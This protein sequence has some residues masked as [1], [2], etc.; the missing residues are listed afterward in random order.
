MKMNTV[1]VL[2]SAAL[3]AASA[4]AAAGQEKGSPKKSE[5][6]KQEAQKQEK[7]EKKSEPQK[8]APSKS[9][10]TS[11]ENN[12][13]SSRS[14]FRVPRTPEEA[15]ELVRK[16][17]SMA[18]QVAKA[19]KA[20]EKT[21]SK[22]QRDDHHRDDYS[23]DNSYR[24]PVEIY[25]PSGGR[26]RR[27]TSTTGASSSG[28]N[29]TTGTY[30]NP[31]LRDVA[32]PFVLK[33][34]GEYYLYRTAV[35]GG[36]DVFTSCDLVNWTP[37][38]IVWTPDRPDVMN[39]DLIWAP[40]IVYDNGTF[41]LYFSTDTPPS[42]TNPGHRIWVA[43]ADSPL[44]PFK[45][46]P[47]PALTEAWR[48]DPTIFTDTDGSRYIYTCMAP[49]GGGAFVQGRK[50]EGW[51]KPLGA[52]N[53]T[54]I[55][56]ATQDW[57]GGW[58]EGPTVI[59]DPDSATPRY[60]MLYS[61]GGAMLPRYA[62][63]VSVA[64]SPLGPW[65][66]KGLFLSQKPGVPGPG[67]QGVTLAPDNL[68][69]EILYHKK[70]TTEEGWGRDLCVD[71][72]SI[73]PSGLV[74]NAP[75]LLPQPLPPQ[76]DFREDFDNDKLAGWSGTAHE[77]GGIG[78]RV[79]NGELQI[80]GSLDK[81]VLVSQVYQTPFDTQNGLMVEVNM[82]RVAGVGSVGF[83]LSGDSATKPITV[84]LGEGEL[85]GEGLSN[86][87]PVTVL[88]AQSYTPQAYHQVLVR[89]QAAQQQWVVTADGKEVLRSKEAVAVHGKVSLRLFASDATGAFDGIAVTERDKGFTVLQEAAR[90]A[91][92]GWHKMKD[93]VIEQRELG[94]TDQVYPLSDRKV[95]AENGTFSVLVRGWALGRA[96][97]YPKYGTRV[98]L[99]KAGTSYVDAYIDPPTGVLATHAV[100]DG[101]EAFTWQNS[102]LPLGFNFTDDH[103]ITIAWD[104]AGQ[105]R[106][107]V[108][109]NATQTRTLPL[110][111]GA[112]L[113]P[114]LLTADCRAAY[115]DVKTQ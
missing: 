52:D 70:I 94:A 32:D 21:A 78:A 91:L 36:I 113:T 5:P 86:V 84:L 43:T 58:T 68:T 24:W 35:R 81:S 69:W 77:N 3:T 64:S 22:V 115:R 4:C 29:R 31:V 72:F 92:L 97:A 10:S 98:L 8:D 71:S 42:A 38:P 99:N 15:S 25:V 50:F 44:G 103:K 83:M 106:F 88:P 100:V 20:I 76:P 49:P 39:K 110:P 108:D 90:P 47:G 61:G 30:S 27:R 37:G 2:V 6:Q 87:A 56:P 101:K 48:I 19:S 59:R 26:R 23:Y 85:K 16:I 7:Q 41:Y 96:T 67:H 112:T 60:F 53:W 34:R 40:E 74:T 109:G 107:D 80:V 93:G 33:W 17:S 102:V 57:E 51:D 105:W 46:V 66:K 9:I 28:L 13:T 55:V 11:S 1:F 79:A 73:A 89:Y 75:T 14:G 54:T 63:G 65:E 62:V 12:V 18:T 104:K 111:A 95:S 45:T 114:A 82:R